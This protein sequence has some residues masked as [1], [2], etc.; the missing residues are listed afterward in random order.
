MR[1][2]ED[3]GGLHTCVHANQWKVETFVTFILQHLFHLPK[4]DIWN[5][6]FSNLNSGLEENKFERTTKKWHYYNM[7]ATSRIS[8]NTETT[9]ARWLISE[10]E[11]DFIKLNVSRCHSDCHYN[12]LNL[13][14]RRIGLEKLFDKVAVKISKDYLRKF[15]R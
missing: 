14:S 11:D 9:F 2:T 5:L 10:K 6:L 3:S 1:T 7:A 4:K 15:L 13:T 8:R 12:Q